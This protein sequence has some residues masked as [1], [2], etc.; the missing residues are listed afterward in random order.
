MCECIG[1]TVPCAF[2][3]VDVMANPNVMYGTL[4]DQDLLVK[5]VFQLTRFF[6]T[7]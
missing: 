7:Y 2:E 3:V 1:C 4:V 5:I 6:D